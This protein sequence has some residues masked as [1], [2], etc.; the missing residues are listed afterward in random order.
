MFCESIKKNTEKKEEQKRI[1]LQLIRILE[2][3]HLI[4]SVERQQLND[5]LRRKKA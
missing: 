1:L 4:T 2:E 5:R 3:E